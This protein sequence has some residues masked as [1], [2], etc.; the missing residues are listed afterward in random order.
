[1]KRIT[2]TICVFAA[3]SVTACSVSDHQS[4][5]PSLENRLSLPG[6]VSYPN[7]ITH[8]PDGTIYLGSVVSGD[9]WRKQPN[10][11]FERAFTGTS[12]R[13]AGTALEYDPL[14]DL[15]WVAS[16][17][18]LGQEIDGQIVKRPNR[19]AVLDTKS[20]TQVWSTE[21][22]SGGFGNDFALDGRG[23]VF[24][25]DSA[26]D[27]VWHIPSP[28]SEFIEVASGPSFEPGRLGPAGI[29]YFPTGKLVT[30]LYSDGELFT[31][32]LS[33][34]NVARSIQPLNLERKVQNPDGLFAL[35]D[36][37]LL[38]I[39]GSIEDGNGKLL[40]VD[41]NSVEPHQ[42]RV[43]ADNI[44]TPLNLTVIGDRAYITESGIRHLMLPDRNIAPPSDFSV[45]S[46]RLSKHL[47]KP[48]LL[49]A[50]GIFPESITAAHE[51]YLFTGSAVTGEIFRTNIETGESEIFIKP[52]LDVMMSAQGLL[53]KDDIGI[54]YACTAN[55]G[56]HESGNVL[57]SSL[58]SYDL[59]TGAYLNHWN[60]PNA[61]LCNDISVYANNKLLV[62][63]TTNPYIL[64]FDPSGKGAFNIWFEHEALG[65]AQF[66]GNGIVWD[67]TTQSVFLTLFQNGELLRIN[68]TKDNLPISVEKLELDRALNGA[69]ALRLLAPN[70]LIM[71]E[72]GLVNGGPGQLSLVKVSGNEVSLTT[73]S[74]ALSSPTSGALIGNDIFVPNTHFSSLFSNGEDAQRRSEISRISLPILE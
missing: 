72:N 37:Q 54:L 5:T 14:T 29:A 26:L 22:P 58:I 19:I 33:E 36:N 16:P 3:I 56:K 25:T 65:G 67:E 62:S 2:K 38:I 23:G 11:T 74:D 64:E 48:S 47:T 28:G 63:D 13:F 8:T 61:G 24:L 43:L 53:A 41:L 55:L 31:I 30:G 52:K 49:L 50:S 69:D 21:M 7:G 45:L 40:H 70:T 57:P 46:V 44:D 9:I 35:P 17:D 18:F 34:T 68:T 59:E 60:L 20:G 32:S 42:V 4:Q 15:L 12:T 66:N 6:P 27:R 39:E 1:M 73:I 71:F 10:S 51:K